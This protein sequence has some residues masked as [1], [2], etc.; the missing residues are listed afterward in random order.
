MSDVD[1]IKERLNIIDVVSEYVRLQKTGTNWKACCPFHQEKTPSFTVSEEK[2]VWHCFGCS[3]GGDIFSFV[4]EID[5]LNF[6]ETL[7][8]LADRAGITLSVGLSSEREMNNKKKMHEILELATRFY[9][10][11]LWSG[12]GKNVAKTYLSTRGLQDET[13]KTF[14]IGYAPDGWRN[15]SAF[16]MKRGCDQRN[17]VA[18]GLVIQKSPLEGD[19][20]LPKGIY[21]R[22]RNRV[23]FPVM[24]HLGHVVGF[25]ARSLLGEEEKQAKYINTP[26]TELYH[27]SAI[28]YGIAQAK[29]ALKEKNRA[30]LV[31]GNMD[32]LAAHQEKCHNVIAVSGT[33]LTE[34][35]LSI[36]RRYAERVTLCFDRDEA[37]AKATVRS[38]ESCFANDIAVTIVQVPSGKDIA[39]FVKEHPGKLQ[40]VLEKELPAMEYF[41]AQ[42]KELH[43]CSQPQEQKKAIDFVFARLL[44]FRNPIEQMQWIKRCA[45]VFG[46]D[47]KIVTQYFE[48]KKTQQNS[49]TRQGSEEREYTEPVEASSRWEILLQQL[50]LMM[51]QD[52]SVWKRVAV[53]KNL[54]IFYKKQKLFGQLCTE[55]KKYDYDA[56]RFLAELTDREMQKNAQRLMARQEDLLEVETVTPAQEVDQ[57][58]SMLLAELQ[59]EQLRKI[60]QDLHEAEKRGD[61]EAVAYLREE[62]TKRVQGLS[63]GKG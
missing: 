29:N 27:K 23:I 51:L 52:A 54:D 26:E 10:K 33:A 21:D 3:R 44:H 60:T 6:R 32:V 46:S 25:S 50:S 41:I 53:Q 4:M 31:E 59:R 24:D 42:A 39:D 14:R 43:D 22:F 48:Q 63:Q 62:F 7:M 61:K 58:L 30:I 16:L 40:D 34:Q 13:L 49:Q 2:Q 19:A 9:E 8:R 45:E 37:G 12:M 56:T 35:H 1:T 36:V 17:I 28:L 11:Q 55:G 5:G 20:G 18:T 38:A 15:L 47:E 57:I